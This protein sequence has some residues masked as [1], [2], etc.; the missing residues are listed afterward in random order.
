MDS[1]E[2]RIYRSRLRRITNC[3]R[4]KNRKR[5][6]KRYSYS[7][8]NHNKLKVR[9]IKIID[10]MYNHHSLLLRREMR[11]RREIIIIVIM[12]K[13]KERKANLETENEKEA[14]LARIISIK[15]IRKV[16]NIIIRTRGENQEKIA[17]HRKEEADPKNIRIKIKKLRLWRYSRSPRK[18]KLDKRKK[19]I[20]K[21]SKNNRICLSNNNNNNNNRNS[22]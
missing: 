16:E 2:D 19:D 17:D 21:D 6:A 20:F 5:K 7:S 22:E 8:N 14:D 18:I 3:K 13:Q 15:V 12:K 1:P 9:S 10:R 4:N 11:D